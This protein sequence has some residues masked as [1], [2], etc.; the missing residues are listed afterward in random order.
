MQRFPKPVP[1]ILSGRPTLQ[2]PLLK[3]YLLVFVLTVPFWVIGAVTGA[4]LLP[5]VP[6]A[7]LAFICP[8]LA[9]LI[10]VHQG[11]GLAGVRDLLM[12]CVDYD[13]IPAKIWYA[14]IF[15][16]L[17][18][19]A[20]ISY[21]VQ[22]A[23]GVSI[24]PLQITLMATLGLLAVCFV[25]ALGEEI[26]WTGYA[27]DPMQK[28]WHPL[29]AGLLLGSVWAAWHIMSLIQAH[30]SVTWMAW[31]CVG[32]LAL[33]VVMVWLYNRAGKSV[34]AA[35]LFHAVSNVC[36]QSYPIQ[37]SYFDPR[38]NG[39]IMIG[40]AVVVTVVGGPRTGVKPKSAV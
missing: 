6:V 32:T 20:F 4:Q 37:G 31:W 14:P 24:P 1:A 5:G 33:R 39:L 21:A 15:L 29:S 35:A 17:P 40:L 9:A 23:V 26:G 12:R 16:L 3:F 13:R 11:S 2:R 30:R 18:A 8:G 28:R 27:T 10:L 19:V 22:R 25:M 7:A 36:W 38:I 34:F